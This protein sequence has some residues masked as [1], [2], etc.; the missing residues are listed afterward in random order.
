MF[1]VKNARKPEHD[2][3]FPSPIDGFLLFLLTLP[4]SSFSLEVARSLKHVGQFSFGLHERVQ[5]NFKRQFYKKISLFTPL[6]SFGAD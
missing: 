6:S 4:I 5:P 1:K 3:E 2:N